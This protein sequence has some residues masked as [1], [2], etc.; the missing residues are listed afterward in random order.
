MTINSTFNRQKWTDL[1]N[2]L[3]TGIARDDF[4]KH[5]RATAFVDALETEVL[6]PGLPDKAVI[7]RFLKALGACL[8]IGEVEIQGQRKLFRE[9]FEETRNGR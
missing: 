5:R 3:L 8:E 9:L 1:I 2:K 4:D 7:D 6:I